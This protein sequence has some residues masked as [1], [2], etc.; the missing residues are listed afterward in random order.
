MISIDS[1]KDED[2][3]ED[4]LVD[5]N[6]GKCNLSVANVN[7]IDEL[8][9]LNSDIYSN[10]VFEGN[11]SG[12]S[13]RLLHPYTTVQTDMFC[14]RLL[15]VF[16]D[17]KFSK[18]E[19]HKY[20]NLIHDALPIPNNLPPNMKKL[21]SLILMKNLFNKKRICLMCAQDIAADLYFCSMFSNSDDTNIAIMYGTPTVELPTVEPR[22]LSLV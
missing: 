21:L 12:Y 4:G 20:L 8:S 14:R 17:S 22:Q 19:H 3:D 18:S 13:D 1:P 5:D 7:H 15:Q 16:R 11:D 6:S 10:T 2:N 9:M